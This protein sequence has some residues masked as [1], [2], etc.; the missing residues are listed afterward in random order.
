LGEEYRSLSSSLSN[1]LHSLVT[2]SLLGQKF[3]L[4]T[5]FS[6]TLN[7]RSSLNLGDQVLHPYKNRQNYSS[8]YRNL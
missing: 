5:I 1:F 7:L 6:N 3:L 4:R 8:L 2:S